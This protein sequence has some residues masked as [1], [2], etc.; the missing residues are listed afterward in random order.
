MEDCILFPFW[1]DL[2]SIFIMFPMCHTI[3]LLK[4]TQ[5]EVLCILTAFLQTVIPDYCDYCSRNRVWTDRPRNQL[6]Q[7]Y[8]YKYIVG[9]ANNVPSF[10]QSSWL[11][12]P[13]SSWPCLALDLWTPSISGVAPCCAQNRRNGDRPSALIHS[14][15]CPK[16]KKFRNGSLSLQSKDTCLSYNSWKLVG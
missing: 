1:G 16:V 6:S 4:S 12:P 2:E 15:L 10:V 11:T 13:T 8:I 5:I 14:E 3:G 9:K 7:E